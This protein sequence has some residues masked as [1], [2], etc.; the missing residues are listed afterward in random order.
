MKNARVVYPMGFEELCKN[1]P[2]QEQFVPWPIG[3]IT[4]CTQ[5]AKA[6]PS[7]ATEKIEVGRVTP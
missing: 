3:K 2:K 4:N 1:L 6:R 7:E 5:S